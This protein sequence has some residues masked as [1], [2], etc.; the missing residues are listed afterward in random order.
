MLRSEVW[1]G[2]AG[3][4]VLAS[5]LAR[6]LTEALARVAPGCYNVSLVRIYQRAYLI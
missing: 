6:W 4:L 3:R 5:L 2:Q 1:F